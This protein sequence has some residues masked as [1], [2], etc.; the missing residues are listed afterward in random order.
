M[1][2]EELQDLAALHA[3]G[4]L[5][6]AEDAAF[7]ERLKRDPELADLVNELCETTVALANGLAGKAPSA[8]ARDQ[9]MQ[10]IRPARKAKPLKRGLALAA[11]LGWGVAALWMALCFWLWIERSH[12]E[13]QVAVLSSNEA[14][15]MQLAEDRR[16]DT[17]R[18]GTELAHV[19][20]RLQRS[21][22]ELGTAK[23]ELVRWHEKDAL[24]QMQIATLQSTVAEFEQGVAVVVWDSEKHEGVLKLERMPPVDPGKDYQLWVVDPKNPK[25]VNAGV[26]SVDE[27]GFAKVD[28]KPVNTVSEAAKF[29]LSVEKAGGVQEN[30]GPIILIGP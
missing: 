6:P 2:D 23:S 22:T 4:A 3:L 15:A 9:V 28:F 17:E 21:E 24:A 18:L 8:R 29:A 20:T 7:E 5:E 25:P 12:L 11:A 16:V 30:E 10:A 26:V 14:E 1:I 27:K 19:R 13:M